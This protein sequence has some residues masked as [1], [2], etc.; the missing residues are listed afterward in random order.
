MN[1]HA[2]FEAMYKALYPSIKTTGTV[3]PSP[4]TVLNSTE[5]PVVTGQSIIKIPPKVV[6]TI[7]LITIIYIFRYEIGY[8]ALGI[9]NEKYPDD[10]SKS[11]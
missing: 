7:G 4:I 1:Q 5:V 8:Y 2:V 11:S 9:P 10:D 3:Q 6:V